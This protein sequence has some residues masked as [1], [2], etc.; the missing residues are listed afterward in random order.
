LLTG[1]DGDVNAMAVAEVARE[2]QELEMRMQ[3]C[4]AELAHITR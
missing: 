1:Q 4:L 2:M 3:Q